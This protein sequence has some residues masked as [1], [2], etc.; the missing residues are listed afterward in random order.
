MK[1]NISIM[2]DGE[3]SDDEADALMRK[4]K[5]Q[6]DGKNEWLTY[7]LIG[8]TL[9]QPDC[10]H[11]HMSVAFLERLQAEP[12]ILAPRTRRSSKASFYAMSA[13]AS[14]MAIAFLGWISVQINNEPVNLQAQQAQ[15]R[16][17]SARPV[18]LPVNEGMNDY[19]LAHQEFSPSNDVRGAASYIR[20]V[21]VRQTRVGQ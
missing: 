10:T 12:T 17:T 14:V 4:I 19:L 6:P 11:T 18:V 20:T 8:D 3:L 13:A 2:M 15:L 7:H 1:Q 9:R 16:A 5:H 21:S